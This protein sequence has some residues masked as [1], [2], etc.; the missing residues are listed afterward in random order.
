MASLYYSA[1]QI[2]KRQIKSLIKDNPNVYKAL[3][4][5]NYKCVDCGKKHGGKIIV[6]HIDDSRKNGTKNMNNDLSNLVSV[7][8]F[9]HARRHNQTSDYE[10]VLEM[11]EMGMTFQEIGNRIGVTRQRIHQIWAKHKKLV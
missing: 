8:R 4:R 6:H 3:H 9:C 2:R 10:D 11:R 5:D 1:G 7:C